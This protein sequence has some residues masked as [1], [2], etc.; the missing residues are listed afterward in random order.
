MTEVRLA[1][2]SILSD[3]RELELETAL[4]R[5]GYAVRSIAGDQRLLALL[6]EW[7]PHLIIIDTFAPEHTASALLPK[8]RSV[9][10]VPI[11]VLLPCAAAVVAILTAGADDCLTRP[12]SS[13]EL[14]TRVMARLRR[15]PYLTA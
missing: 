2:C 12:Y 9:T 4:T 6:E 10:E 13:K 5:A 8:I 3:S 14:C 7:Q 15:A 1:L 11:I